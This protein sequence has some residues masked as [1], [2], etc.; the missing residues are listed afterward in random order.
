M[1]AKPNTAELFWS[2]TSPRA[3][4][5]E[6]DGPTDAHGYGRFSWL[7]K[8]SAKAHRVSYA[9]AH[10]DGELPPPHALVCHTCDNRKCVKPEHLYLGTP[11]DNMND[12]DNRG[13]HVSSHGEHNGA[14]KLSESDVLEIRE[15]YKA[16]GCS[17]RELGLRY[18]VNQQTVGRLVN[19]KTWRQT[20]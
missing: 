11:A 13:R 10:A 12:R 6:W 16:G 7:G 17:Q 19:H 1:P 5:L 20:S 14:S 3:D 18:G 4:C 15:A 9:I 8:S 2:R